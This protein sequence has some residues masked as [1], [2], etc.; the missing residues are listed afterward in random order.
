M[1]FSYFMN[2]IFISEAIPKVGEEVLLKGW[3]Y[4]RRG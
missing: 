2:R 1:M 4:V 3:V